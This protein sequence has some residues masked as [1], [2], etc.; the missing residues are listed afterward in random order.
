[1]VS[2]VER[3]RIELHQRFA[4]FD[5]NAPE[6]QVDG[7]WERED[8]TFPD[9]SSVMQLA[10]RWSLDPS[11]LSESADYGMGLLCAVPVR[12]LPPFMPSDRPAKPWW[13]LW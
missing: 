5:G 13:K 1:M 4:F 3:L 12:P 10:A 9:E 8:L 7:Y 6:A 2:D 11:S